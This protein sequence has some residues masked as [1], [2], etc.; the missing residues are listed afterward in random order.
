MGGET[1][2]RTSWDS[3]A[4]GGFV[5]PSLHSVVRD[6]FTTVNNTIGADCG[7]DKVSRLEL[8]LAV[9]DLVNE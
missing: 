5:D 6:M 2:T 1:V 3:C 7:E 8:E 4:S 9:V